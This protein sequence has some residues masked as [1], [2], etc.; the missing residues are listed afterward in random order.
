MSILTHIRTH[1]STYT[2]TFL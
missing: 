2:E 1:A